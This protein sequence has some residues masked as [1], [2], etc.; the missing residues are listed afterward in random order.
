MPLERIKCPN[1]GGEFHDYD[2]TAL[3][4]RCDRAGCGALFRIEQAKEF[5]KVEINHETDIR[6]LRL[7]LDDAVSACDIDLMNKYASD[8]RRLIP[9]DAFSTY[10]EALGQKKRGNYNAYHAFFRSAE[11]LTKDEAEKILHTALKDNHFTIHDKEPL[12]IFVLNNF[13]DEERETALV[14]L[15]KA[16]QNLAELK[17]RF[18]IV[19]RDVFICHSSSDPIARAV[20]DAL[21]KDG[22]KCWF[23]QINLPPYTPNYWDYI[24]NAIRNCKIILVVASKDS[25]LRDDPEKEMRYAA[26]LALRRLELKIDDTP[27]N[28][29]FR[30]YFDGLPWVYLESDIQATFQ[31]LKQR[32]YELLNPESPKNHQTEQEPVPL[33]VN[34]LGENGEILANYTLSLSQG[35][36]TIT[37]NPDLVPENYEAV[38]REGQQI[39]VS[40]SG[41]D[42]SIL[43]FRFKAMDA[44]V[45]V[46]VVYLEK[47]SGKEL[48]RQTRTLPTGEHTISP[49]EASLPDHYQLL[50][51][52]QVVTVNHGKAVPDSVTFLCEKV[53]EPVQLTIRYLDEHNKAIAK[54]QEKSLG[55]GRHEIFASPGKMHGDYKLITSQPLAFTVGEDSPRTA[56]ITFHYVN[57]GKKKKSGEETQ[58]ETTVAS[59]L[60]NAWQHLGKSL[61]SITMILWLLGF[62]LYLVGASGGLTEIKEEL[63][64]LND[65]YHI[66]SQQVIDI[67]VSL[68][69]FI[70]EIGAPFT[71]SYYSAFCAIAILLV[72]I[73]FGVKLLRSTALNVWKMICII[74]IPFSV[75]YFWVIYM[76]EYLPRY[77]ILQD[78][79]LDFLLFLIPVVLVMALLSA[80]KRLRFGKR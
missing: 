48:L 46:E 8:I 28:T 39:Q 60:L 32:V 68:N 78:K 11:S 71:I 21:T 74:I 9:D 4:M 3:V 33:T 12:R 66:I 41:A 77:R 25:M 65:L 55:A 73:L 5:A 17:D 38:D 23:S 59:K 51:T 70:V 1:C 52:A 29:F 63:P 80:L 36:H 64:V 79:L 7:L 37:P 10:C 54:P 76:P 62:F 44:P 49:D 18:A 69:I 72:S 45:S 24:R 58:P 31:T 26:E 14:Q 53:I 34:Y 43:N 19:P 40:S 56:Q 50:D 30:H 13:K 2:P 16:V 35:T 27:H 67:A 57:L 6:N 22:V 75:I 42:P 20:Y 61:V 15:D 47:D